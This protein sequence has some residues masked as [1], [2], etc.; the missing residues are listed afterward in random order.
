MFEYFI[1]HAITDRYHLMCSIVSHDKKS[2]YEDEEISIG[3]M[4]IHK[5][6]TTE[7]LEAL[8]ATL[9]FIDIWLQLLDQNFDVRHE[10]YKKL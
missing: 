5:N 10:G 2:S 1:S 3:D 9:N 8:G 7:A 4:P 6:S